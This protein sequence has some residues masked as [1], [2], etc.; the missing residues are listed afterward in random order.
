MLCC[1]HDIGSDDDFAESLLAHPT[2]G[3]Q[4]ST[5]PGPGVFLSS[6]EANPVDVQRP[7]YSLRRMVP[8]GRHAYVFS[9]GTAPDQLDDQ[10]SFI[11]YDPSQPHNITSSV[12][13][14]EVCPHLLPVPP[15]SS[16]ITQTFRKSKK[17]TKLESNFPSLS[18]LSSSLMSSPRPPSS[19]SSSLILREIHS[20]KRS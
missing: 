5:K 2:T 19:S 7:I 10:A 11:I 3:M 16:D 13:S 18:T 1:S 15:L 4:L 6:R 8:P 17:Q 20:L 9:V 12:V 14:T